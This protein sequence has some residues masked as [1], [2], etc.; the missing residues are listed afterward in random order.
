[1]VSK[2]KK[3]RKKS[4]SSRLIKSFNELSPGDHVV[5]ESHGVGKYLG[6]DQLVIDGLKKDYLKIGYSND[7]SLYIP[8]EQMELIQKYIGAD[9]G[10]LK[11]H[12]LGGA[13]W[14]RTK[15][16]AKKAIEDMTDELLELY[17][18]RIEVKG[19]AYSNDTTWQK[20][21]EDMFPYEET[22]D[23]LKCIR[24]IKKDMEKNIVMD[25]LLC[26]DVGY[27]KTEVAIRAIFKAV[28]ES[29]Q[30][31]FFSSNNN[32]GATTLQ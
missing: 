24:E 13:E 18:S 16:K 8:I 10:R 2:R 11:L 9:G 29:K 32:I 3:R 30:V 22:Q 17:A 19:Y 26:G 6:V 12:R 7:D 5:H 31:A 14:T 4:D 25:R 20:Q 1:M 23:Q 15:A 21:F 27:G 28:M